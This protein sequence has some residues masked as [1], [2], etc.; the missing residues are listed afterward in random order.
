VDIRP[1]SVREARLEAGLS[2]AK[3]A[4]TNLSRGA[5]YLI[6][7]DRARPSMATLELIA[8]RTAKPI[9]FFLPVGQEREAL[10]E[11]GAAAY[12]L[13]RLY[14]AGDLDAVVVHA[15]RLLIGS[16]PRSE[17]LAHLWLGIVD[18]ARHEPQAA[19]QHL[20]E[21]RDLFRRA[22][23][24]WRAAEAS[25]L[26]ATAAAA[27]DH[28]DGLVL[29]E[30]AIAESRSLSPESGPLEARA[31][32]LL[33]LQHAAR[34]QLDAAIQAFEAAAE[35]AVRWSRPSTMV[36]WH[37]SMA[38]A[39]GELGDLSCAAE[40]QVKAAALRELSDVWALASSTRQHL[41]RA[42]ASAGDHEGA[43]REYRGAVEHCGRLWLDAPGQAASLDL[44]D[45]LLDRGD[46]DAAERVIHAGLGD[47]GDEQE[48]WGSGLARAL[49]A[50]L[51]VIREDWETADR[52]FKRAI[53]CLEEEGD[54]DR[55]IDTI[56]RYAELLEARGETALALT[57][58]K[59]VA[60]QQHPNLSRFVPE[61]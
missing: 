19:R 37:E 7:N 47:E 21:A 10:P 13:D 26:E 3:L 52:Q 27:L 61:P 23:N 30:Q 2:L 33:G 48:P 38:S 59:L 5:I 46:A 1:G 51:A 24:P 49:L 35:I 32:L 34:G 6:E 40:H 29:T 15:E 36:S 56:V 8:A 9:S 18:L 14:R 4:G 44:A 57:Y 53:K 43:I 60:K 45:L 11:G 31:L 17:A 39:Y 41:A 42:R 25:V 16:E 54:G 12:V 55:L 58:W 50:R 20:Q 28:V 22:S